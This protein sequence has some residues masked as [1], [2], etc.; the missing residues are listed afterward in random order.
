MTTHAIK[1][2]AAT[3][4]SGIIDPHAAPIC[5]IA[6]GDTVVLDTWTMWD[7]AAG[8]DLDLAGALALR[9]RCRAERRGPHS[10][11]GP[12][13]VQSA[14]PGDVLKVEI[15]RLDVADQGIN[16]IF[17]G[18]T[19]RGLLADV[20]SDPELRR[21]ELD[22]G[23][24]TT[25]FNGQATIPLRP[26]LG[27]MG[28]LPAGEEPRSS[29]IP[30]PF[31]G[32]IDCPDLVAGTILYLPVFVPG[33]GFYT[34]DAHAV[35]GAGE[36]VQTALETAM[37]RAELRLTVLKDRAIERP[38]AETPDHFITMGLA[39]DL[40]EAAR[41]A[42]LDMIDLLAA[43]KDMAR[44]DAYA[45]CSLQADLLVTQLVNGVNGIHAR[46]PKAIFHDV[47]SP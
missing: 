5:T 6:S 3:V 46:M 34:G 13:A 17:P 23:T 32:N 14:L 37:T 31:G 40:R 35:Q 11:T 19:S 45:L 39:E 41:Q 2:A 12:I 30:G 21:F 20:F 25:R 24:M 36:V 29:A 15:L 22:R 43:T 1:A 18:A 7:D 38:W 27:I 9:D 42:V 26:F 10:L 44:S 4:Q 28:V 47:A 16:L 33:A 8:P